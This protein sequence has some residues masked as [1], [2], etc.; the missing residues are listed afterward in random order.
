VVR[1]PC[2]PEQ[3]PA[4]DATVIPIFANPIKDILDRLASNQDEGHTRVTIQQTYP[5]ASA[6]QALVD[7]GNGTLGKLVVVLD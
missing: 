2:S 3:L 4:T 1:V 5:L 7:F 6:P